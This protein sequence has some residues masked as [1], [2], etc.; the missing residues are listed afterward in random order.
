MSAISLTVNPHD[1]LQLSTTIEKL[2]NMLDALAPDPDVEDGGDH[3]PS[4]GWPNQ[5]GPSQL[6]F[7]IGHD[8]DRE[9]ENE[10]GGDINDEPQDWDERDWDAGDYGDF[11]RIEGG[12]GL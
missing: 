8:D 4:L 11:G 6:D 7:R 1:R 2:I 5:L 9:Q 3:E 12:Q 10:H